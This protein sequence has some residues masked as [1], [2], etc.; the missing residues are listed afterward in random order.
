MNPGAAPVDRHVVIVTA[1]GSF[2]AA[3]ERLTGP[4]D[5]VDKL[6]KLIGWVHQRGGL[7]PLPSAADGDT[8]PARVWLVGAA[9]SILVDSRDSTEGAETERI[10]QALAS[11]VTRGWELRARP[12]G[13]LMLTRGQGA[14]RLCVEVLAEPQPWLAAG[15]ADIAEDPTELG[16]RLRQW[17]AAVGVLPATSGATSAAVLSDHIMRARE[18]RRGPVVSAPTPLPAWVQ[19]EVRIQ[20]VWCATAAEVEQQFERSD[21]VVRLAQQCPQ[22]ASAGMLTLGYGQPQVLD[23]A[24]AAAAAAE[25]KRRFGLWRVTLPPT[26]ELALPE[27][28][29]PPHPQMCADAAVEAW[30][31]TEDIDGLVKDVRDGGAGL[32]VEQLAVEEAIVWPQQSR[33]LEAW[34]TRL[35]EARETFRDDLV[36]QGLV[37]AAAADYLTAL[38]EPDPW[39]ST[40][41]GQHFQPA[42]A[43]AIATHVRFRGRRAAMRISREYRAWPAY[44]RD[45][46]MIYTPG[47]EEDTGAP[48]DLS[49]SH[50]RL[51]R[52]VIAQQVELTDQA[53][54][55][56]L[57]A[58][59]RSEVA[60]ALTAALGVPADY[61]EAV[62]PPTAEHGV[63]EPE[64]ASTTVVQEDPSGEAAPT[65]AG[66]IDSASTDEPPDEPT[67]TPRHQGRTGGAK[68]APGGTPAAVLDTDGLWFPDGTR[69]ELAHPIEHVGQVA[70]LA[71][72][73]NLGFRLSDKFAEPGQI[74][75]SVE[76]CEAVGI[77]V[78]AIDFQDSAKSLRELTKGT[79]FVDLA[80]EAGWRFGGVPEGEGPRLGTW[81]RVY[82]D[83]GEKRG[84][85]VVLTAGLG[86]PDSMPIFGGDPTPAQVARRLDLLANSLKFPWKINGGVTAV[87]LMLQARPKSWSPQDW[88]NVVM[89]PST[90]EPPFGIGDVETDFNWSREPT[91]EERELKY[92]H[93]YD[94]GG[95]YVAGIAGTELPIGEPKH[96][97]DGVQFDPRVPGYYLTVIPEQEDWRQPY[98]LNPRG[99]KFNEPKWV[100][101]ARL[102][103]A[104]AMGYEPQILEAW[105]WPQHGRVLLGW[106]ERFRDA[107]TLLDTDDP[108]YQ[109]ARKQSKVIRTHGIG[110]IGSTEF[111]KGK[112]GFNPERRFHIM[113]KAN[114]NIAY[115]VNDIGQRTGRWPLAVFRDTV[116]YASDE[117]DPD[118]AWPGSP[119]TYGRGFGQYKPERSGLLAD[120]LA[121]LNEYGYQ[122]KTE[123]T[124]IDEWRQ[125]HGLPTP[126]EGDQ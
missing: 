61:S 125:E 77:D 54:I 16:R 17:Y 79:P 117:I 38:A 35:R 11:L 92:L 32:T 126:N 105:T 31:S 55:A 70:Q 53:V 1:A 111:L 87:D 56:V 49:D 100:C 51:G 94:R 116:F 72:D 6:E 89:A 18:G 83:D 93:A 102:E 47:R 2:T 39:R 4:V 65:A 62:T 104:I 48:I 66:E 36:L 119:K 123:L 13:A 33:V 30:V 46:D 12:T 21:V 76:V 98:V 106:Y 14:Q 81:T 63:N 95:S 91:T 26:N 24:A 37:E 121:Y 19:P 41:W 28:L 82:R 69:L 73:R 122:G 80:A 86:D 78:D 107:S 27:M 118:K 60:E 113:A 75:L 29:P 115:R 90:T 108:D 96:Q 114:A 5:D 50:T 8:E 52:L 101:P 23:A 9:G 44:V 42:W 99:L 124:P 10:G 110:I 25:T 58:E 22:L 85:W 7:Q 74:W 84:V 112:P 59:S 20:P 15:S 43:A 109:A 88:K 3:G 57:L 64:P 45:A 68:T 71:Y 97:T 103:R 40:A 67:S 120:Q 34:A